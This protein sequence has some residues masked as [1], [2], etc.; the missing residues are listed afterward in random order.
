M[1]TMVAEH[2]DPVG[3][4][5][6]KLLFRW[7]EGWERGVEIPV[8]ELCAGCPELA[9]ELRRRIQRLRKMN[10]MLAD[11]GIGHLTNTGPEGSF[12]YLGPAREPGDLGTLGG[13]RVT[14]LLP[15]GAG[16]MGVVFHALDP[17]LD[18]PVALKVIRP[19]LCGQPLS[20]HRF[21]REARAAAA[22]QHDH[23]VPIYQVGEDRGVPFIA[24]P[25][26]KG[27]TLAARLQRDGRL[28]VVETLRVA[29][30]VAAGLAAAHGHGL[31]HRDIKPSNIW[32][33][34]PNG[35]VKILD[36][37]LAREEDAGDLELTRPGETLGTLPYMAPEQARGG[38]ADRRSDLFSLGSVMY[39]AC[40]GR[41]PFPGSDEVSIK[42]SL[43]RDDPSPPRRIAADIPPDLD[44]LILR[45]LCKDPLGRPQSAHEVAE[46]LAAAEV[47]Y[48]APGPVAAPGGPSPLAS[49]TLTPSAEAAGGRLV[50]G[51]LIALAAMGFLA[52][53]VIIRIRDNEGRMTEIQVP[54]G[55]HV[56]LVPEGSPP[57]AEGK[58]GPPA[59]PDASGLV[60]QGLLAFARGDY[61]QAIAAY[62]KALRIDPRAV[63]GSKAEIT[64]AYVKRGEASLE[65]KQYDA[66]IADYYEAIALDPQ[67]AKAYCGRGH[68]WLEKG[69]FEEAIADYNEALR[70]EPKLFWAQYN[71]GRA[72][73]GLG[74]EDKALGDF[75][76]A[77]AIDPQNPYPYSVRGDI[78]ARRGDY[79]K[80]IA[81][82]DECLRLDPNESNVF[83]ARGSIR[84]ARGEYGL[85]LADLD[86]V[87]ALL[88]KVVPIRPNLANALK[89]RA[90]LRAT[91]PD[92]EYRDSKAAVASATR[93]CDLTGWK[94]ASCLA[95]LAAALAEAGDFQGA[96]KRQEEAI[97][98]SPHDELRRK[99]YGSRL[100]LFRAKKPYRAEMT[101]RPAPPSK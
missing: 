58:A 22:V 91:C 98:L 24:M 70:I 10:A 90:W 95:T 32:L 14:R 28:S 100:G 82:F 89:S 2:T 43:L 47:T 29:R 17:S 99:D 42:A 76:A 93:A 35:R 12:P 78:W 73:L 96:V 62:Q 81:Y 11:E 85:A 8:E 65:K 52:A 36:F 50:R 48:R 44:A 9:S 4:R 15:D 88:D 72:R 38:P 60:R 79:E 46:A 6:S 40:T 33:E 54:P 77:A 69:R 61:D 94:D 37:G 3:D 34:E 84:L 101:G 13:Y 16:G 64:K 92:A 66:A 55:S 20:R 45:L 83:A 27:E 31:V 30:E 56:E 57:R 59:A 63:A 23:V 1:V 39:R 19:E 5:L 71:H 21:L 25:L 75:D 87:I 7:E 68:A 41:M 67:L 49:V 51:T 18:R 97:V 53:V 80:A 86:K 26:L 74:E